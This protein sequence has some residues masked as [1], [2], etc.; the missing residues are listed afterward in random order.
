MQKKIHLPHQSGFQMWGEQGPSLLCGE[1]RHGAAGRSLEQSRGSQHD[2]VHCLGHLDRDALGGHGYWGLP[3]PW[4]GKGM[5]SKFNGILAISMSKVFN[6]LDSFLSA[7]QKQVWV[8]NIYSRYV[9][10]RS[11]ALCKVFCQQV[12][13]RKIWFEVE[14]LGEIR[15]W[16]WKRNCLLPL[17]NQNHL[18]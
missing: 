16:R 13:F 9:S 12:H 10:D 8:P 18:R 1:R 7:G 14:V 2:P 6:I 4:R 5:Q 3:L 11:V 15:K 17:H